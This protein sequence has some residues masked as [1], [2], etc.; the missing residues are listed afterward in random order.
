MEYRQEDILTDKEKRIRLQDIIIDKYKMTLI[1]IIVNYPTRNKNNEI[2]N[3]IIQNIDE[4]LSDIFC[5][6]I[7]FK[8]LRIT[9]EGPILTIALNKKA[10]D[11]K[12]TTIEI[13]DKHI[14][15]K[16]IH[17][18]VYDKNKNKITRKDLGYPEKKCI[19]CDNPWIKCVK[20]NIHSKEEI[21]QYIG[22]CY[23]EYMESFY[24]KKI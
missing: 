6:F 5:C 16:C 13:E 3:N 21:V 12:K 4:I 11:V 10:V 17:I 18:D 2:T 15:G 23:R 22:E 19:L 7:D 20:E 14:L 9:A 8:V 24:G 1:V